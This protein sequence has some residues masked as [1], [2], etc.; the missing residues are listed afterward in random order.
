MVPEAEP[1]GTGQGVVRWLDPEEERAWRLFQFMQMRLNARLAR[2]LA[3]RSD[4]SYQD[5]MVLVALTDQPAGQMRVFEL[6]RQ[7]GW[8]KSR[9]SHQVTRMEERGLVAKRRCGEDRRG[10][11]VSVTEGGWR[12]IAGAAPSHLEAVRRL[13]VDR[14]SPEQLALLAEVS[15]VVLRAVAD[16]EAE[17]PGCPG[18]EERSPCPSQDAGGAPAPGPDDG[19]GQGCAGGCAP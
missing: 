4:L 18:A 6:A 5:Y 3:V 10:S 14:L 9:L 13:F 2:D 17:E 15:T 16:D 19:G 7:L 1:D 12:S 11:T 8:E